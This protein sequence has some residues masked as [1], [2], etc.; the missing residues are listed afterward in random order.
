M[1]IGNT[2]MFVLPGIFLPCL[3]IRLR[4]LRGLFSS[5]CDYWQPVTLSFN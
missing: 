2:S 3:L 5:F 4:F 1:D